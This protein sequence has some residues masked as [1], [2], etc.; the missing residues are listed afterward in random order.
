MHRA[1]WVQ[2]VVEAIGWMKGRKREQ[3]A[4]GEIEKRGVAERVWEMVE[5]ERGRMCK[6]MEKRTS[7]LM[8]VKLAG[9]VRRIGG[10]IMEYVRGRVIRIVGEWKGVAVKVT[11]YREM[12]KRRMGVAG[13]RSLKDVIMCIVLAKEAKEGLERVKKECDRMSKR[14]RAKESGKGERAKKGERKSKRAWE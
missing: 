3:R 14:L 11:L 8:Y 10:N 7:C 12:E 13:R 5:K 2:G 9:V 1:I 6:Q 4:G